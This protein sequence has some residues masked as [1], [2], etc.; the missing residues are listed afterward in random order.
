M[1]M[2]NERHTITWR[3]LECDGSLYRFSFNGKEKDDEVKGIGNS[4][5]FGARIYD[6]R[7]GRWMSLDPM[8]SKY[9][10]LSFPTTRSLCSGILSLFFLLLFCSFYFFVKLS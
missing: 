8:Q 7:L 5:D 9:P 3:V 2:L 4:L 6:S 10:S 1:L